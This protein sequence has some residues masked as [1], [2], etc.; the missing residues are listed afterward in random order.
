MNLEERKKEEEDEG[1]SFSSLLKL[2]YFFLSLNWH[3]F[4]GFL[5]LTPYYVLEVM[6][7]SECF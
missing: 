6:Y 2:F 1:I 5:I 3:F 4:D 7:K